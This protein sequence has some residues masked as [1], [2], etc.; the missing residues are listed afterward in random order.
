MT[1]PK[2]CGTNQLLTI[3]DAGT[4]RIDDPDGTASVARP[5]PALLRYVALFNAHD[6][7][8]IRGMLA[9]DVR[10]DLVSR[11]QAVGARGDDRARKHQP[12]VFYTNTAVEYWGGG[13]SAALIHT[14][15]DGKSD[16]KVPDNVRIYFL[17]GA[18]HSPARFPARMTTGQQ[19]ENPV[20]YWWTLRALLTSMDRWVRQGTPPPA[21]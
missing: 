16:L 7:D 6:W 11:R 15:P 2:G 10:L 20:E 13:R 18:Q 21:S 4:A 5:S 19:A 12:K 1:V 3:D 8:G 14:T 9:G 17:T